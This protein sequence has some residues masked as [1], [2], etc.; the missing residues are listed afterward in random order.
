MTQIASLLV[1]ATVFTWLV[2]NVCILLSEGGAY[3]RDKTTNAGGLMRKEIKGGRNRGILRYM[4]VHVIVCVFC[5][6]YAM[7][8]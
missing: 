1:V 5:V 3:T 2:C 6:L 8:Q 7:L 4:H